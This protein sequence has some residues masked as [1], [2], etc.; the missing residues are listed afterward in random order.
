MI[1]QG[2]YLRS[3]TQDKITGHQSF[4]MTDNY[5]GEIFIIIE[6]VLCEEKNTTIGRNFMNEDYLEDFWIL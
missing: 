5:Y 1:Y 3:F 4:E 6:G 2:K